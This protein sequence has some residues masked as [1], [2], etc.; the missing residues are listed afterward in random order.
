MAPS[1]IKKPVVNESS[2]M[3][4]N[5][6]SKPMII[7]IRDEKVLFSTSWEFQTGSPMTEDIRMK[8]RARGYILLD[9]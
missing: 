1:P 6:W 7:Y 2:E 8:A 9:W 5:S 4:F 3:W